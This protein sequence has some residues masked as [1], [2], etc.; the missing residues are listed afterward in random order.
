MAHVYVSDRTRER[1]RA[2]AKSEGRS[3]CG[4]VKILLDRHTA[5]PTKRQVRNG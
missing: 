3:I 5:T 4:M 1:I 2:L